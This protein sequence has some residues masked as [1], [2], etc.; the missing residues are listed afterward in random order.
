[1][2]AAEIAFVDELERV[3]AMTVMVDESVAARAARGARLLDEKET[4][5]REMVNLDDLNL[6]S[7]YGCILGQ[8]FGNY[9]GGLRALNV[10]VD[11]APRFG[12]NADSDLE[13]SWQEYADYVSLQDE[14]LKLLAGA[15]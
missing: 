15:V 13:S 4:G 12:F 7:P 9:F 2:S 3:R 14:W 10:S 11:E 8:V 6:V 5:W 1:M